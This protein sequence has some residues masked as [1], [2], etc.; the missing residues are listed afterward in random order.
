MYSHRYRNEKCVSIFFPNTAD[1]V[2]LLV[3]MCLDC[4]NKYFSY[5]PTSRLIRA[6]VYTYTNKITYDEILLSQS[7]VYCVGAL[8]GPYASPYTHVR[9]ASQPIRSKNSFRTSISIQ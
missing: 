2:H 4:Q 3:S 6:F 9:T 7:A 1:M 8:P 5:G